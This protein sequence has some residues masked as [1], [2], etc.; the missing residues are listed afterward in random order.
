MNGLKMLGGIVAL[1]GVM[2]LMFTGCEPSESGP[3][4][5]KGGG[6]ML[7]ADLVAF[8]AE[9]EKGKSQID[10]VTTSLDA[11]SSAADPKPEFKKYQAA[12]DSLK[13]QG[14]VI[15][16]RADAM[17]SKGKDYF[18]AWEE[19]LA[20]M[21]T[22]EIKKAIEARR[23]ELAKNYETV[24]SGMAKARE[25]YDKFMSYQGD[26]SKMMEN[27]LNPSGL[28]AIAPKIAKAKDMAKEV[29]GDVDAVLGQVDKLAAI[30]SPGK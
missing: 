13:S 9:V 8:K 1:L 30:Y 23:D 22:P 25:S 18:K 29:K 19:Q 20:A 3:A 2:G 12:L 5:A 4:T 16:S 14:N 28:Q 6:A 11:T 24:T 7:P 26:L 15:R 21:S 27:D 17:K 10:L